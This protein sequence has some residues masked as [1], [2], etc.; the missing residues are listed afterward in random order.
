MRHH[1]PNGYRELRA[2]RDEALRMYQAEREAHKDNCRR[3]AAAIEQ[4]DR[5]EA[6]LFRL[7]MAAALTIAGLVALLAMR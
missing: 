5:A 1:A 3:L 7:G 6:C 2:S 4:R